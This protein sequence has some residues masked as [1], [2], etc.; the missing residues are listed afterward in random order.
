MILIKGEGEMMVK[1]HLGEMDA[2]GL[3][4]AKT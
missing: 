4:F 2:I 1:P 3:V